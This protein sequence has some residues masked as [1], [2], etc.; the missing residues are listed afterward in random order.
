ML[1][2]AAL[3]EANRAG[4]PP[5]WRHA[6]LYALHHLPFDGAPYDALVMT[7]GDLSEEPIMVSH[8]DVLDRLSPVADFILSPHRDLFMH[9]GDSVLRTIED[10][11]RVM[12]RSRGYAPLHFRNRD[13]RSLAN[14]RPAND[15]IHCQVATAARGHF[16]ALPQRARRGHR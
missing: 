2:R 5:A 10:R 3:S 8:A 6:D 7:G 4:Q 15:R 13:R 1:G 12:R 14:R 11:P 16:R 9:T